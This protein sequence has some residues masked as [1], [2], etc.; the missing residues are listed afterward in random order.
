MEWTDH[1]WSHWS[2]HPTRSTNALT[3]TT[4]IK[5]LHMLL[6]AGIPDPAATGVARGCPLLLVPASVRAYFSMTLPDLP[7]ALN[8]TID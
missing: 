4:V 2:D 1:P 8:S 5:P 3:S 7:D 6:Q